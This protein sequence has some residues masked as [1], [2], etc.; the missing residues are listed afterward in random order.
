MQ[1]LV[2]GHTLFYDT[3]GQ[4]RPILLLHGGT[5]LDHT[6]FRPW[7]DPL[8]DQAQLIF[9]DLLGNGRSERP[10]SFAGITMESWADDADGLR[11][12]LGHEKIILLGHSFGGF[13]AQV[14][15]LR[16]PERLAGLILCDTAPALDYPEVTVANA[17]AR[18]T[19]EQVQAVLGGLTNPASLEDDADWRAAWK[20]ILPLYFHHYDPQVAAAMDEQT[21]YSGRGF[22]HGFIHC[23]PTYNVSDRL[24]KISVPTLLLSGQDDWITPPAYGVGRIHAAIPAA[25]EVLFEHSG[26]FPFIEEQQSFLNAVR[27][28]LNDLP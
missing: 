28:W 1:A 25:K 6:Y 23:L 24:S 5:G 16:H 7:L 3:H 27:A 19:P 14:Y 17:Q 21:H 20:A 22:S 12:Y 8:G 2:N 4:G 10:A 9:S 18:G 13:I 15:A 11:A 26:H